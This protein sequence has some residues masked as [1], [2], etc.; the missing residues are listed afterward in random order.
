MPISLDALQQA[1][2]RFYRTRIAKSIQQA[3][4]FGDQTAFLSHSHR[5]NDYAKG[6]EVLLREGGW[7][8]YI[9]GEDTEMPA[10]PNR[11]TAERI[12][13]KIR[14]LDW[15]LF[16]ATPNSTASKWCPWEIGYADGVKE[17]EKILIIPTTDRSGRWYGNEYL[18]L[19]RQIEPTKGGGLAAFQAGQEA[20]GFSIG[21]LQAR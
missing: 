13:R 17:Y 18:Q 3:R 5:D 16:L 14:E 11:I 20:G 8:L 6:L 1:S 19:Y 15:F 21:A 10:K 2:G 12:Q 9:D 4:A 7:E